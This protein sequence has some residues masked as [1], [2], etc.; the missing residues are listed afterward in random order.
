M[1]SRDLNKIGSIQS[2]KFMVFNLPIFWVVASAFDV[3]SKK[4]LL[5]P[6]P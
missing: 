6:V 1:K 3:I 2:F 5:N 4:S